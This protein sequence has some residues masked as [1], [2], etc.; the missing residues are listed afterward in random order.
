MIANQHKVARTICRIDTA[1]SVSDN[2]GMRA[3]HAHDTHR[4][5]QR[6]HRIALVE[7][8]APLHYHNWHISQLAYQ[9][10]TGMAYNGRTQEVGD[11][12]VRD[13]RGILNLNSQ[14]T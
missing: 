9:Q 6:L 5:R 8:E 10:S 1:S 4:K 3:E 7:V 13:S 11:L 2:Q 12:F 14:V